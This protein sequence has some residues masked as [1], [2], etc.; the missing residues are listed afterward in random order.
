MSGPPS[1][2]DLCDAHEALLDDGSLRVVPPGLLSF[3][4]RAAFSGPAATVKVRDD[5]ALVAQW[6][7]SPGEGR[8]LVVDGGN[9]SRC[10]VVGG[11]LAAAAA[12][13]G[14]SGLVIA[15]AVR[16]ADEIDGCDIGVRALGLSPRRSAKTGAGQ[17]Q[18]AV[19]IL[20]VAVAPGDW[21]YADRDGVLV[22]DVAL[23]L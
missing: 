10:A 13:N 23:H 1:T 19:A 21:I 20:G 11:R 17:A 18:V 7:R 6:V 9:S 3:G 4:R 8:V 12:A 16:D 5:N 2:T 14:W 22:S 15:G